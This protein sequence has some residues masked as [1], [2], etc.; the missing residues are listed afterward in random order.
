MHDGCQRNDGENTLK[1]RT[2]WIPSGISG[3]CSRQH[4]TKICQLDQELGAQPAYEHLATAAKMYREMDT[5]T[6]LEQVE[7]AVKELR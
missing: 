6:W 5:R 7:A 1:T 2:F 4:D 3:R